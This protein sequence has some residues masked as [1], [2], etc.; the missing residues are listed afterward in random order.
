[1]ARILTEDGKDP[2]SG[3]WLAW[4]E[5]LVP[6]DWSLRSNGRIN[7]HC[8][9]LIMGLRYS[10]SQVHRVPI[11]SRGGTLRDAE[12]RRLS[13]HVPLPWRPGQVNNH[14]NSLA[15][16]RTQ[17]TKLTLPLCPLDTRSYPR[18]LQ[19]PTNCKKLL[20]YTIAHYLASQRSLHL[21]LLRKETAGVSLHLNC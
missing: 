13:S 4:S 7:V 16:Q 9:L 18:I 6:A 21:T 12:R 20:H 1:M 8:V 10:R 15:R 2:C 17:P 5:R 11:S 14:G 3:A 19:F